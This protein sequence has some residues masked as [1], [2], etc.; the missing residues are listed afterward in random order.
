MWRALVMRRVSV[1]VD[2]EAGVYILTLI[3]KM[4]RYRAISTHRENTPVSKTTIHSISF[5]IKT[6]KV[7]NTVS[8]RKT[9]RVSH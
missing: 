9:D 6:V 3:L 8:Y 1:S 4:S 2:T 5:T 7:K